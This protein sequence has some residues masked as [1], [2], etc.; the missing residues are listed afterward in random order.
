MAVLKYYLLTLV[1]MSLLLLQSCTSDE[2]PNGKLFES[3]SA[4]KSNVDF[5]NNIVENQDINFY[6]HQYLYN[7]G[8]VGL[9]DINNDGLL[10]I[11]F[12]STQGFD[13]L[14][15]NKGNFKFEDI[16]EKAGINKFSGYKT[17]VNMIDIDQD[18]WLDIYVCRAGWTENIEEKRNLL[19]INNK[20]GTFTE[21]AKK[22]GL[23]EPNHSIQSVFFDYD[24]D[25][26]LDVFISNYPPFFD[27]NML[28]AIEKI[29]SPPLEYSD[30]LYRNEGGNKYTDVTVESGILNYGYGLGIVAADLNNDSWTDI[31]VTSDFAP[32]DHY[33]INM[34]DGTFKEALE[35]N[36]A[37]CSYFA[38]GVDAVD[39]DNDQSLDLFVGEMLAEDNKR[40]KT[41]MASMDMERFRILS[42]NGMYYQYMR[43]S[44]SINNGNGYFSDVAHFSGIDK[45]DWSWSCLFGDYDLDGDSDLLV[46]NG[47]LKDTQD[48]DFGKRSNKLAEKQNNQLT[49]EDVNSLLKSTPIKNYAFQYEGDLKFKKVSD[50]WGF[51]YVGFSHGM[52]TGDIDNDGDLDVVINNINSVATIYKNHA[53]SDN[54]IGFDLEGKAGNSEGLNT[55]VTLHT[56]NGVQFKEFQTCRG[57]QS[58]LDPR[59]HFGLPKNTV[60]DSVVFVWNDDTYQ[61][62]ISPKVGSYVT[63]KYKPGSKVELASKNTFFKAN[64]TVSSVFDFPK[65]VI[66]DDYLDQV[67]IPHKL[68]QLGPALAVGDINGDKIDDIFVGGPAGLSSQIYLG[69]SSGFFDKISQKAFE[70]DKKYEDVEAL[71]FDFDNDQ[72]L[73]LYVGSGSS[74]FIKNPD[75]Q[76][77]RLYENNGKG[78]F[79]IV[80]NI[81]DSKSV[82][83][84]I[85][86]GD[87][88]GDGDLD[89]F[90]GSRLIP[91][92]YPKPADAFLLENR[93]GIFID[94][95]EGKAPFLKNIGLIN[96]SQWTDINRDGK[97]DLIFAGEWT[98]LLVMKNNDGV[99]AL[100]TLLKE[101]KIGWWNILEIKD[102]NNDGFLDIVAG[103]LGNNYKYQASDEAPFEIYSDDM[104]KNGKY[105]IVLGYNSNG[106]IFPVR[107]LQCSSEQIPDLKEKFHTYEDFGNSDLFKVYGD[108]LK[109]ALHYSA[110]CFKSGILWGNGKGE[111]EFQELPYQAQ[112]FPVQAIEFVDIEKDGNLDIILSGNWY[113]AEIETPRADAGVGLILKNL[114]N[115]NFTGLSSSETG[116]FTPYDVRNMKK[117][118]TLEGNSIIVINNNRLPTIYNLEF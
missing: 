104:D 30:K 105:D 109:G 38:M 97:L 14:Y 71:F 54:F 4:Q 72:D 41:N 67:L 93:N 91:G 63:V 115:K 113:M 106:T 28:K 23:D 48:K 29:K 92:Y 39:I 68:S 96:S 108:G 24:K 62:I 89:L 61:K 73:D 5:I 11:Y 26:D 10:D 86:A 111:F 21:S 12:T 94:V 70:K 17:G 40:Q 46:A 7:G 58:S 79:S 36:F 112:L 81:P 107:G 52:A 88:D 102:L 3:I 83:G 64:S 110:N 66:Y 87:F 20:N 117:I 60:V 47:W 1:L 43:N 45:S 53:N 22:F 6:K 31:Y 49:Y 25:G 80:N 98:D 27:E 69:N 76:K 78:E 101:T 103:N 116:F 16:S 8:G 35:E 9:G 114:G 95:T 44:F 18:G 33:F 19:F 99:F 50:D 118:A 15:I 77:D 74:E 37:H 55:K 32:R 56:S 57:F 34:K 84:T 13:K 51:D 75:L 82:T 65:E 90:V 59:I 85:S 100:E 42:E 2:N